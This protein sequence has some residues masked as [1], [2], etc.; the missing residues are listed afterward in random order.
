MNPTAIVRTIRPALGV[1]LMLGIITGIAYPL[2]ITL[3]AQ[4]AFPDQANGS[5]VRIDGTPVGSRLIGQVFDDPRYLWGRPSAAG[6]GYDAMA[7]AGSNLGPT[8]GA[9]I[10]RVT[11]EL[12][13]IQAADGAGSVPIERVT[14]SASGLDPHLSPEGARSQAGRIAAARGIPAEAVLAAIERRTE[15]PFGGLFGPT[16]VNVLL[17]NLDLDGRLP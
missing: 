4:L 2:G 5:L 11:A 14:A 7:S 9:L 3:A 15:R 12:G 13:R 6:S 17:V 1:L 8:S 10:D 16:V